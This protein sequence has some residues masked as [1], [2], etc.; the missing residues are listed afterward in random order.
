MNVA[1]YAE[2]FV[3][4]ARSGERVAISVA[5]EHAESFLFVLAREGIQLAKACLDGIQDPSMRRVIETIFFSTAGGAVLGATVGSFVAGP[6]GAQVGAL[7]GA[8]V[9]LLAAGI[10]LVIWVE[11]Q[12]GRLRIS[13]A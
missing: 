11:V 1:S 6:A 8:G 4:R 7:V 5:E 3:R 10:A 2:E 12:P 13:M 9:G